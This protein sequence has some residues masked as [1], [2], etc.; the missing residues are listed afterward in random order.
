MTGCPA[1]ACPSDLRRERVSGERLLQ[2]VRDVLRPLPGLP[3]GL[4]GPRRRW[5]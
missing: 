3:A 5:H 1:G 4:A 2:L